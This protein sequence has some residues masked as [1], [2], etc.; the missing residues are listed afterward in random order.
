[1]K[2]E[3]SDWEEV[4]AVPDPSWNVVT[5]RRLPASLSA[6]RLAIHITFIGLYPSLLFSL[7][8]DTFLH[9]SILQL[10]HLH[11]RQVSTFD[12]SKLTE[13]DLLDRS[14]TCLLG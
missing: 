5:P 11:W 9:L 13:T 6:L 8:K 3:E 4:K 12:V 2:I 14:T 10:L 7:I 1:V